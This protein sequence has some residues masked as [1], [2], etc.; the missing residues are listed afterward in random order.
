MVARLS[1]HSGRSQAVCPA[2]EHFCW[3]CTCSWTFY[4]GL[5]YRVWSINLPHPKSAHILC[6]ILKYSVLYK[7]MTIHLFFTWFDVHFAIKPD[8]TLVL[9][10]IP[11]PPKF[12]TVQN[13]ISTAYA[14]NF[15][16]TLISSP[17]L[18]NLV[19]VQFL[20]CPES[21]KIPHNLGVDF[22]GFGGTS[23]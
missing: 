1:F 18:S 12:I 9:R 11:K 20:Y 13:C 8:M 5:T 17:M 3:N 2:K 23:C 4:R 15:D 14:L 10:P 21:I 22:D 19:L 16:K 6:K 7:I